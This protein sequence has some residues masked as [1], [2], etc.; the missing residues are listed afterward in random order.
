[1][2]MRMLPRGTLVAHMGPVTMQTVQ[3]PGWYLHPGGQAGAPSHRLYPACGTGSSPRP[4][5]ICWWRAGWG[6]PGSQPE[7]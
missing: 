1:M 4:Q 7:N 2:D 6:Q 5:G 3:L